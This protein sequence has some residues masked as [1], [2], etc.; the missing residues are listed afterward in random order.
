MLIQTYL[1]LILLPT[2][3]AA[4]PTLKNVFLIK[5]HNTQRLYRRDFNC[6]CTESWIRS[7]DFPV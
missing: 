5:L 2:S 4:A 7:P 1:D 3:A 6:S